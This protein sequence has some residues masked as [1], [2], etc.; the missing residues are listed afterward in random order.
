MAQSRRRKFKISES[1]F[2]SMSKRK[3]NSPALFVIVWMMWSNGILVY[4]ETTSNEAKTSSFLILV[5]SIYLTNSVTSLMW[6][7]VAGKMSFSSSRKT[8][9]KKYPGDPMVVVMG[10][11]G[12]PLLWI[13][14]KP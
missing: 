6:V 9:D 1:S 5:F 8:L 13:F 7:S 4:M 2:G 3:L 11:R 10:R 12:H 14:G